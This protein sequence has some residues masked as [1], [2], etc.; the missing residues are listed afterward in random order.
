MNRKHAHASKLDHACTILHGYSTINAGHI[1]GE[2][3]A[4]EKTHKVHINDLCRVN[5][6]WKA[7][8]PQV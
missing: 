4:D 5:V 2:I 6:D 7:D 1:H 8:I 3:K